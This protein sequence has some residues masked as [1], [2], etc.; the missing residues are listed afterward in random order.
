M[1]WGC[2]AVVVLLNRFFVQIFPS[3]GGSPHVSQPGLLPTTIRLD[4]MSVHKLTN[5]SI[6]EI[7]TVAHGKV[8]QAYLAILL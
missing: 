2:G 5:Y 1:Y 4:P 3:D 7:P 6:P 8:Y